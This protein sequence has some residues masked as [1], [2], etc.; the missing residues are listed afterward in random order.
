M[1]P[2]RRSL[3][4]SLMEFCPCVLTT[5]T[6]VLLAFGDFSHLRGKPR[7]S[8]PIPLRVLIVRADEIGLGFP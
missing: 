4:A 2:T 5:T 3:A 1:G 8:P 6:T 7:G